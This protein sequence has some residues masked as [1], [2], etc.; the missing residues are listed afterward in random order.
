MAVHDGG[1][2][3]NILIMTIQVNFVP[4]PSEVGIR[5]HKFT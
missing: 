1:S 4:I 3:A 2:V 5:Q